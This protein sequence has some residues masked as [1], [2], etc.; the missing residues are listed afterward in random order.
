MNITQEQI[1]EAISTCWWRIPISLGIYICR[2]ACLPCTRAID[3][4]ECE[5]IKALL[6]GEEIK[7]DSR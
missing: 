6:R 7:N 2:G 3:R 5:T 4:G 1:D